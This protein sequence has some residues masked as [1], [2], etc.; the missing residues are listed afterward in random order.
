[1]TDS[2]RAEMDALRAD[3]KE[4]KELR[5]TVKILSR[6][7]ERLKA[8]PVPVHVELVQEDR[9]LVWEFEQTRDGKTIAR[10]LSQ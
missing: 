6:D 4:L 7:L 2:E 10:Q 3:V 5:R 9:A 1:M 8:G